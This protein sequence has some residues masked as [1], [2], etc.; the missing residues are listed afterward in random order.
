LDPP[1]GPTQLKRKKKKG[2]KKGRKEE[3]RGREE[4]ICIICAQL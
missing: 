1:G 2:R 4:V 3:R